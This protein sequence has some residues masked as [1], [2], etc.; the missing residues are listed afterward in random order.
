MG[1][2]VAQLIRTWAL[3][4][5]A[6]EALI[7]WE[8]GVRQTLTYA[9]LDRRARCAAGVL[10]RRGLTPGSRV[11]LSV[12][13]GLGFLDAWFGGLY[14]GL[15]MLPV[16]PMSAAPELAFRL[17]HAS[18]SALITDS[19]TA[20]LGAEA[21]RTQP[22]VQ[23][24]STP[25][26]ER[27]DD[28]HPG[29]LDLAP[30]QVALVLYTSGTTGKPK[31]ACITHASLFAHTAALVHH[32]LQLREDDRVLACLPLT[33]SY[34]IRMT[35]LAPFFAGA[36]VVLSERFSPARVRELLASEQISW[37]PGVPTM[38]HALA[39]DGASSGDAATDPAHA[40]ALRWCLSA[41]APL[42]REVRLRAEQALA[43]RVCEGYGLTEATFTSIASPDDPDAED[44]VGRPVFG[45][46]VRILDEQGQP[47]PSGE[48]GEVCIRGQN[49]MLG[50][51]D[52]PE[53]SALALR[54]GF[55]HSGDVG[56]LDAAGR[57]R[58]VDRLKDMIL[59]GGFNVYPAEVEAVLVAHPAVLDAV[60]V[61]Q[62]DSHYG[63]EV[64]AVVVVRAGHTLALESLAEFCRAQLSAT[65]LPRLLGQIAQ[66]PVGASGKVQR[67]VVREQVLAGHITLAALPK[68]P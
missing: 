20:A 15:T 6:R 51:L 61:G 46:E 34:G 48:R 47:V 65:K 30:E 60:V 63:E 9:Q 42:P 49:V 64:V 13:N 29:P 32:V 44:S 27:G 7:S 16:P 26:L 2:N 24:I 4:E 17:A 23:S 21:L 11:A 36:T 41:G 62:P 35:L 68:R 52:D 38:F 1:I 28:A 43:A 10:A 39:N 19:S 12:Q 67:R 57:L 33:H 18:C 40:R 50:Y 58:I 54:A 8:N 37:F 55:L 5:P 66:L 59:R 53:A 31:G 22:S 45:V 56:T 14:Q 3:R 25:E